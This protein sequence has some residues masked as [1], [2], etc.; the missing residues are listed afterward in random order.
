MKRNI[1]CPSCGRQRKPSHENRCCTKKAY[2]P[3]C[4]K[5][6]DFDFKAWC[7]AIDA[8]KEA[9]AEAEKAEAEKTKQTSPEAS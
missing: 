7:D 4:Q 5:Y 1:R 8:E 9:K 3:K 6:E 2:S